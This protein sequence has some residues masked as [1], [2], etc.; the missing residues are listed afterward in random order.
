MDLPYYFW[1]EVIPYVSSASDTPYC[2]VSRLWQFLFGQMKEVRLCL[3]EGPSDSVANDCPARSLVASGPN[4]LQDVRVRQLLPQLTRLKFKLGG[5][6]SIDYME[7]IAVLKHLKL[8]VLHL[9]FSGARYRL[10]PL[11]A[12]TNFVSSLTLLLLDL[13]SE[14]VQDM[15]DNLNHPRLL[16]LVLWITTL[17]QSN[18][19]V[20]LSKLPGL[21]ELGLMWKDNASQLPLELNIEHTGLRSITMGR[22]YAVDSRQPNVVRTKSLA[23]LKRLALCVPFRSLTPSLT[24][25]CLSTLGINITKERQWFYTFPNLK[26]LNLDCRRIEP[27][28]LKELLTQLPHLVRLRLHNLKDPHFLLTLPQTPL[29]I[30]H[31]SLEC[32]LSYSPELLT[33][34]STLMPNLFYLHLGA[35]SLP[36]GDLAAFTFANLSILYLTL[37]RSITLS[38]LEQVIGSAPELDRVLVSGCVAPDLITYLHSRSTLRIEPVPFLADS[39][40]AQDYLNVMF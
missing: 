20:M 14:K 32:R 12:A 8:K 19:D 39:T 16:T 1:E 33:A 3:D 5:E 24:L 2:Q 25:E 15:I 11:L 4:V 29:G 10:T 13:S 27:V 35:F 40:Q 6:S 17:S 31:L 34:L 7:L 26:R 30:T 18:L 23:S 21:R 28:G 36:P 37:T 22:F 9:D 38:A